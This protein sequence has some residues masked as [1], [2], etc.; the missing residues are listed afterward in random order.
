MCISHNNVLN[1]SSAGMLRS[2]AGGHSEVERMGI[3]A[4][5]FTTYY[6]YPINVYYLFCGGEYS[7][8][9]DIDSRLPIAR[10]VANRPTPFRGGTISTPNWY[11]K[12]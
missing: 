5:P 2:T 3:L 8:V 9:K 6:W 10:F 4:V 7:R 1:V 12:R 11:L